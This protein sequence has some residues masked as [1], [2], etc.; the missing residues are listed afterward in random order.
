[1]PAGVRYIVIIVRQAP[2]DSKTPTNNHT[3]KTG[4]LTAPAH[5]MALTHTK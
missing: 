2:Y 3:Y 4:R 1:M 5:V